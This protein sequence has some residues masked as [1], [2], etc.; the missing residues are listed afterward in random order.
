MNYYFQK[1]PSKKHPSKPLKKGALQKSP[2]SA[3]SYASKSHV[4]HQEKCEVSD[5][6][7]KGMLSEPIEVKPI[8]SPCMPTSDRSFE[9]ISKPILDLDDPLGALPPKSYNDLIINSRN[10]KDELKSISLIPM[11]HPSL[12]D[13][14]CHEEESSHPLLEIKIL[15]MSMEVIP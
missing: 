15:P 3:S 14:E 9:P 8:L 13:L 7:P 5:E 4:A 2:K 10:P 6:L 1:R 12:E 11:V